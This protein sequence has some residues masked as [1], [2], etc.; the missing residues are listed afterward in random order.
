L[1]PRGIGLVVKGLIRKKLLSPVARYV[2]KVKPVGTHVLK[3]LTT[4]PNLGAAP[5]MVSG[6]KSG[7]QIAFTSYSE[8]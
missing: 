2:N 1:L 6:G 3:R 7:I 8:T 5:V 4:A